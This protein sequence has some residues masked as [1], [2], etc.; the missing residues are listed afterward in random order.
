MT[1]QELDTALR[2]DRTLSEVAL[3][4]D[5]L[6]AVTPINVPEAWRAFREGGYRTTPNFTYR[7]ASG[8]VPGLRGLLDGLD[9]GEVADPTV[10]SILH[11]KLVELQIQLDCLEHR[12]T[13]RF[14]ET[15][16]R[17]YGEVEPPLVELADTVL[18]TYS[19]GRGKSTRKKQ[20]GSRNFARRAE[21]ELNAYRSVCPQLNSRV[22]VRDD[23][24]G[25][26]AFEGH[27]LIGKEVQ[28]SSYR[29][30]ALIQHEVG[31]HIVTY[32]NGAAHR[33]KLLQIGLASYDQTQE[34]VAVFSEYVSGGLSGSRLA[35][36]AARVVAVD[37]LL[38]G[39]GFI[40]V[41]NMLRKRYRVPPRAAFQV[42]TRVFRGGGFPKDAIYLRGLSELLS[43]LADGGELEPLFLGKVAL[44]DV[45]ALSRLQELGLL[46]SPPLRPRWADL[47]EAEAR[48]EAARRNMSVVELTGE[49]AA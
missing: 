41:F 32:A 42:T 27:L 11:N 2:I 29:V 9:T 28:V 48:I 44:T 34:A 24:A 23:I 37:A 25:I 36:L 21:A 46:G 35:Q 8:K 22:Q 38:R 31:T 45:P 47:P 15:S 7:P 1:P 16:T 17:L 12:N 43:Y 20:V 6:L 49:E 30:D 4:V 13:D 5:L 33:L 39:T 10:R 14:L 18:R 26:M 3:D 19:L 40:E